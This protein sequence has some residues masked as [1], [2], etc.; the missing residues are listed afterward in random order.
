MVNWFLDDANPVLAA[1]FLDR[2][3]PPVVFLFRRVFGHAYRRKAAR[4]WAGARTPRHGGTS[5][6]VPRTC[7]QSVVTAWTTLRLAAR[8]AGHTADSTPTM[9]ATARNSRMRSHGIARE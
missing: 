5:A 8:R 3:P 1:K 6:A 9:P 2:L 7:D 4:R